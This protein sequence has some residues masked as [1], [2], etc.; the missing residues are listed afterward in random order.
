MMGIMQAELQ[1]KRQWVSKERFIEGLSV[2]S[3]LPGATVVQLGIFLGYARSRNLIVAESN[4]DCLSEFE[5]G[6][7]GLL[8]SRRRFAHI[9]EPDGICLDREGAVW[10]GAFKEDVV[11]RVDRDGN[12]TD[13]IPLPGRGVACALGGEDGRT[14][15]CIS[16]QTTHEALR[17]GDR[18]RESI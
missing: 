18:A 6:A 16:A 5:I 4:G 7:D 2:V 14:L 3:M 8:T 1:Q 15:F 13:R 11:V 12:I 9:G 17:R 10:V